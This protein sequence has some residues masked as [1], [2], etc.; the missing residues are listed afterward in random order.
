MK[1]G[2]NI[3]ILEYNMD[4]LEI[5]YYKDDEIENRK[6]LLK[7]SNSSK[8][9]YFCKFMTTHPKHFSVDPKDFVIHNEE[10]QN[11]FLN[12]KGKVSEIDKNQSKFMISIID[13]SII[14]EISDINSKSIQD[15]RDLIKNYTKDFIRDKILICYFIKDQNEQLI[16]GNSSNEV[17]YQPGEEIENEIC[18]SAINYSNQSYPEFYLNEIISKEENSIFKDCSQY[19][20]S[21]TEKISN[22]YNIDSSEQKIK[23]NNYLK[24]LSITY[25]ADT[26]SEK[27]HLTN[28]LHL[29]NLSKDEDCVLQYINVMKK[30][31]I[32]FYNKTTNFM[33]QKQLKELLIIVSN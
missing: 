26:A 6:I 27:L 9:S 22:K 14:T 2:K 32:L 19:I 23:I 7:I 5:R 24:L 16:P 8:K 28:Q 3:S 13:L 11:I 17:V 21:I 20:K 29:I 15:I 25:D 33:L 10:N 1:K 30:L 18:S 31:Q 4:N 12:F